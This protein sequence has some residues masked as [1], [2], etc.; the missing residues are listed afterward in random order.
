MLDTQ[1]HT[2]VELVRICS[3][4]LTNYITE[5]EEGLVKIDKVRRFSIAYH[6]RLDIDRFV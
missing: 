4:T 1:G 2:N 3:R 6:L 5:E